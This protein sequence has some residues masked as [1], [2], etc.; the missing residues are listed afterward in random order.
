VRRAEA[1]DVDRDLRGLAQVTVD[2]EDR[3]PVLVGG[4][5][6]VDDG[7]RTVS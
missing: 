4:G 7:C 3:G 2:E 1:P 5:D 6:G